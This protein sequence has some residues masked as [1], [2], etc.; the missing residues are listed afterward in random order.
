MLNKAEKKIKKKL[1]AISQIVLLTLLCFSCRLPDNFGFYQPITLNLAI[2]D[3]P[4]EYKA[5]WYSGCKSGLG[6]RGVGAFANAEVYLE[7][8]GPSLGNGVYQHDP[9]FQTGWGQ[10][11]FACVIHANTFTG[12]QSTKFSPLQ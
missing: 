6:A 1:L 10:G 5:G 7:S 11:W 12:I 4:P 9:A 3:G 2:P 8:D